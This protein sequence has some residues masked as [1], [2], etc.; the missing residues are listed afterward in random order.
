[1][2]KEE[3]KGSDHDVEFDPIA[4]EKQ[5]KELMQ[6][7]KDE[8]P[9]LEAKAKYETLLTEIEVAEMTRIEIMM[10]KGEMMA[11]RRHAE[12]E[13]NKSMPKTPAPV[14]SNKSLKKK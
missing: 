7:Y 11:N 9:F 13:A 5:K 8:T 1:M 2:S 12:G 3:K 10:R 6:F 4:Y 14:K